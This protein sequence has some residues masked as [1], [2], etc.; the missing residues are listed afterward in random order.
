M[1]PDKVNLNLHLTQ[2]QLGFLAYLYLNPDPED[3]LIKLLDRAR[4]RAIRRA[5]QQVHVLQLKKPN[6]SPKNASLD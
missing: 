3:A 2:E 5:E 1:F 4:S 6:F